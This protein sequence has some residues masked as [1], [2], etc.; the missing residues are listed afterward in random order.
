MQNINKHITVNIS[1]KNNNLEW[2]DI[3]DNRS[4]IIDSYNDTVD[5]TIG[6]V[7]YNRPE[8]TKICVESVLKNTNDI[9]FKLI[10]VYNENEQGEGILKYF[11][12]LNFENK[13]VIHITDNIGA[14]LHISRFQN[15]LRENILFIF[16]MML[17]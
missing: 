4:N 10:L 17:L 11:D 2:S 3:Y 15:I 13:V 7:A 1:K 12:T 6:I 5:V 16:Q 9:S 14:L 8:L